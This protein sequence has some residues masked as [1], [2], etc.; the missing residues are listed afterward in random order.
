MEKLAKLSIMYE[1]LPNAELYTGQ[2]IIN[3][4]LR[5][6]VEMVEFSACILE[7]VEVSDNENRMDAVS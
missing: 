1:Y 6:Q 3:C 4:V 5:K 2:N 7:S